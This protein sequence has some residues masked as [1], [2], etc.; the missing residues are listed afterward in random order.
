MPTYVQYHN[1]DKLGRYPTSAIDFN[2]KI[3]DIPPQDEALTEHQIFTTKK[4]ILKAEGARCFLI[5]GKTETIKKYYLWWFFTIDKV[6][7]TEHNF[8]QASGRG[9][10]FKRPIL[11]NDIAGFDEFKKYCGNFGIGFQQIDNHAFSSILNAYAYPLENK[12]N[13]TQLPTKEN[14]GHLLADLNDKMLKVIPEKRKMEIESTIRKDKSMVKLLKERV[15]YKCQFPGCEAKIPTKDGSNYVEVAHI[16]PVKIG[17]QSVIGNLVVLCPNHH[18]EFDLG[19][20]HIQEQSQCRLTGSLNSVDFE[21][22]FNF[23]D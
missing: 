6:D 11:L 22:I 19:D 1:A 23:L 14:L 4:S 7:P 15:G 17:G 5:V 8:Y 10:T 9:H 12:L 18:K 3:D 21:I 20:L 16:D 2:F 13:A